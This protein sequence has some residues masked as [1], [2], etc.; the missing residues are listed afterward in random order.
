[1]L[2]RE[3]ISVCSQIHTKHINT[4]CGQIFIGFGNAMCYV[5]YLL[6]DLFIIAPCSIVTLHYAEHDGHAQHNSVTVHNTRNNN[7][8]TNNNSRAV[9]SLLH[10]SI[11]HARPP[12]STV[13][14]RLS[15]RSRSVTLLVYEAPDTCVAFICCCYDAG[16]CSL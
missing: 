13:N 15:I 14:S 3:M 7:N 9:S 12:C 16:V 6:Y 2:Y 5:L 8:N 10:A 11:R 1:M 4:L